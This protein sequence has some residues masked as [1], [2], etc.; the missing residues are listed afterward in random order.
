MQHRRGLRPPDARVRDPTEVSGTT[1]YCL[2]LCDNAPFDTCNWVNTATKCTGL[3]TTQQSY[4]RQDP[5]PD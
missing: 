5:Q 3:A 4:C 1:K 2:Q